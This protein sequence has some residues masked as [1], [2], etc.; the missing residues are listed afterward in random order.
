MTRLQL[1]LD[2]LAER[3][4]FVCGTVVV[5]P[6][7]R[8]RGI[9]QCAASSAQAKIA[10]DLLDRNKVAGEALQVDGIRRRIDGARD[11]VRGAFVLEQPNLHVRTSRRSMWTLL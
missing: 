1:L 11:V 5:D 6:L 10:N 8:I 2:G 4:E 9:V 7:G 3:N